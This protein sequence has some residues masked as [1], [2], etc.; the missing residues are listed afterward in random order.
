V[1]RPRGASN[2]AHEVLDAAPAG[3]ISRC[4]R[5][6]PR[7][8]QHMSGAPAEQRPYKP[9]A[10]AEDGERVWRVSEQLTGVTYAA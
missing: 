4:R 1:T 7:G 5:D 8:F 2:C 3:V 9:I 10:S 6:Q